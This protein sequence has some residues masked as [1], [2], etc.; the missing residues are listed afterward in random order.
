L[1]ICVCCDQPLDKKVIL[2]MASDR[3]RTRGISRRECFR[4]DCGWRNTIPCLAGN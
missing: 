4:V 3:F 2:P 1:N